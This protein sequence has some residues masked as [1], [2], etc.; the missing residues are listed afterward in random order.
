[1]VR[2]QT[3][4]WVCVRLCVSVRICLWAYACACVRA[5]SLACSRACG[6]AP[7]RARGLK[8]VSAERQAKR[9]EEAGLEKTTRYK[10][11]CE[12]L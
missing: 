7:E 10:T 4:E 9:R 2:A 5:C 6:R 8:V 1:M 12:L 11:K 3:R